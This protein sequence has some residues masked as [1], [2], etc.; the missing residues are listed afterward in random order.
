MARQLQISTPTKAVIN[1]AKGEAAKRRG[2]KRIGQLDPTWASDCD[3]A[4]AEMAGRGVVFQ[5][6]DLIRLELVG[7]PPHPNC[8]GPRFAV[9]VRRGIIRHATYGQSARA[10]VHRSICHH[11]IGTAAARSAAA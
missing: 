1:P 10:T 3:N 8:W 7:E 2:M 6:A 9:A 11:W 4:I 5:A